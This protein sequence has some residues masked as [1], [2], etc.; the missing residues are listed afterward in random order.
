L[1]LSRLN[2]WI[3]RTS[4]VSIASMTEYGSRLART[5]ILSHLLVREQ[6]GIAVAISVVLGTAALVTDI[7]FDKFAMVKTGPEGSRALA[8]THAL[9]LARGVLL[10]L[11]LA[12]TA[13]ASAALFGVPHSSASFA[14]AAF[15]P[16]VG[17][18]AHLGIKQAQTNYQ[19]VPEALALIFS[20]LAALL[21]L[22][23]AVS[24][25]HD[26]RAIIA[27]FLTESAVYTLASHLLASTP[28]RLRSDRLMFYAALSFGF[29]LLLNGIGLA[30]ISQLDRALVGRWFGVETLAVY[31]VILSISVVPISLITRVIGVMSFSYLL[32]NKGDSV[33]LS[34]R[35][36][37]VVYLFA[38]TS[39]LYS[40]FVALT[41]DVLAPLV[42]GAAYAVS[43][44]VHIL[45]TIIVF[46]R[47]AK[48][49]TSAFLV[50]IGKTGELAFFSLSTGAGLIFALVF[51]LLRPSF[52]ALLFGLML[53]EILSFILFIVASSARSLPHGSG[54]VVDFAPALA[55]IVAIVGILSWHP[56]I[57]LS[58]RATVF[59]VGMLALIIQLA[60]GLPRLKVL[61]RLLVDRH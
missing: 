28:Y 18:F 9:S 49:A 6:F 43:P 31:A 17:S 26:H 52:E 50:A 5:V 60:V 23:P 29:P 59:G 15:V 34:G 57:T 13:P 8:A 20:N 48:G 10:A 30:M 44:L 55:A 46:F 56:Q 22:I 37:S 21:A 4:V 54:A 35:Y 45:I 39:T 27:S 11:V 58:A 32:S 53:G 40:L 12:A 33:D 1:N 61:Q 16:L 51:L 25:F 2:I 47:Q 7:S 19:Y 42:F 24:I 41:L 38:M 3:A 36:R 14:V